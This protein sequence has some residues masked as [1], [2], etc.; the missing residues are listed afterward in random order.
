[1]IYPTRGEQDVTTKKRPLKL[2]RA[3]AYF[4]LA[5]KSRRAGEYKAADRYRDMANRLVD[6]NRRDAERLR[7]TFGP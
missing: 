4:R 6:Q 2:R 5:E 1:M 3:S 7:A